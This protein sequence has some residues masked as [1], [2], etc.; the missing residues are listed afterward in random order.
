MN[1]N[2]F[3]VTLVVTFKNYFLNDQLRHTAGNKS[4]KRKSS[5]LDVHYIH[6]KLETMSFNVVLQ[7][8]A[9]SCFELHYN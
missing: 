3:G 6:R 7:T 8:E 5:I 2:S 9:K 4:V 1:K